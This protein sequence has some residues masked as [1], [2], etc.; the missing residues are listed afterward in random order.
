MD[1]LTKYRTLI[2][3]LLSQHAELL[4]CSAQSG[5]ESYPIFDEVRDHYLLYRSGWVG[6]KRIQLPA[7]YIRLHNGKIWIEED[8]TE[9][10][11]ATE[12][13]AADVPHSDI[14]LAFRHPEL[15]PF[16]EFAVA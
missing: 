11:I 16:T 10:G 7:I 3:R 9:Q 5:L 13:L 12:L 6:K 2:M 1:K 14:V 8:Y 4:N 15:R